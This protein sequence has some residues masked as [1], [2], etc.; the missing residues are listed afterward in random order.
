MT[1]FI[2]FLH[3]LSAVGMGFY[4]IFP[5][6]TVRISSLGKQTQEG[7]VQALQTAN[8]IGQLFLIVQLLTGGYLIGKLKDSYGLGAPWMISVIV[9]FVLAGAVTGMLGGPLKRIVKNLQAGQA[10]E[11]DVAKTKTF[12]ILVSVILILLVILM[13]Y[14]EIFK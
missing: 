14:P 3:I 8:R 12:S 6:L 7:F 5:L 13:V 10:V 11:P 1:K 9:L 2:L 4:L